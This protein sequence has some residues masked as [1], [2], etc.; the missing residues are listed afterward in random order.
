M[1]LGLIAGISLLG[2]LIVVVIVVLIVG[3]VRR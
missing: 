2:V 3:L 1:P